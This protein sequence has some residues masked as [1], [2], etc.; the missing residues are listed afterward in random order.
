MFASPIESNPL[1]GLCQKRRAQLFAA[2]REQYAEMPGSIVFFAGFEHEHG[3]YVQE[4]SFYYYTGVTEP[5]AV[6]EIDSAGKSTLY[7]PHYG[8]DRAQWVTDVVVP[9]EKTA[10]LVGVDACVPLGEVC[11][12]INPYVETSVY[13]R[14]LASLEQAP[15][16][17]ATLG[18]K[19]KENKR[20][21]TLAPE[22][23]QTMNDARALLE[24][25]CVIRPEIAQ[26]I[27]DISALVARQ[28]RT[29]DLY[30]IEQLYKAI[31]VSYGAQ[32]AAAMACVSEA[33]ELEVR[34]AAEYVLTSQGVIPAYA[35]VVAAGKNATTLHHT[36]G[37]TILKKGD[38]V[39]VDCGGMVEHYCGDLTRTYP[40]GGVFS[41]RQRELYEL[42]LATQEHVAACAK[43]G[44]WLSNAEK[45]ELS[46]NH[47]ARAFMEEKMPGYSKYFIHGIGHFLGLDVH[48]VGDHTEPLA[49]GDV[50]TIEP[51]IYIP[52][53]GI[54]IRIEDD[55]WMV[56]DGVVCL[57]DEL[58]KG[59]D[60]IQKFMAEMR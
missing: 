56:K 28:R 24:R 18:K 31:S 2:V 1:K 52:E 55:Y 30:E 36:P 49:E 60:E 6:L 54:G 41:K 29:K 44:M 17:Q 40:V 13:A 27:I 37:E 4:S 43:P 7:L 23:V 21:F 45:P 25:L 34:A 20:I 51:G 59:P 9:G 33:S 38:L 11:R 57:S 46:L 14:L 16:E 15:L 50:F 39:V 48:D 35:T 8:I 10:E 26:S 19:I 47:V 3:S 5:G 32:E 42:V 12:T 22:K 53:E 58:P